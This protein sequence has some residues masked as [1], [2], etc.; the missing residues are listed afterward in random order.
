MASSLCFTPVSSLKAS[1]KPGLFIGNSVPGKVL[2]ASEVI[3][4][5]KASKFQSL[6][7][8]PPSTGT[9]I[10]LNIIVKVGSVL[11]RILRLQMINK[12]PSQV[13]LSV[14]TVMEMVPWHALNA[15]ELELI[16]RTTSTDNSK[17]ADYAGFAGI[18]LRGRRDMLC[19]DCNG[20]GF[21]GGFMS[22][23]DE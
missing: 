8:K 19:G 1:D 15:K 9:V 14:L 12:A 6:E 2:R 4:H 20:A 22:T 23:F 18:D 16:L 3:Q 5:S 17:P 10:L 13:A 11:W 21:I 7:V